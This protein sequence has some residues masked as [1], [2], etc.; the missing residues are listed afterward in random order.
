[1]QRRMA[2]LFIIVSLLGAS[3]AQAQI[4]SG[5]DPIGY[6]LNPF[7][8]MESTEAPWPGNF[9]GNKLRACSSGPDFMLL[10]AYQYDGVWAVGRSGFDKTPYQYP[11]LTMPELAQH[12]YFDE[13]DTIVGMASTPERDAVYLSFRP[14]YITASCSPIVKA[15]VDGTWEFAV[16]CEELSQV[17]EGKIRVQQLATDSA[18]LLYAVVRYGDEFDTRIL[19]IDTGQAE[20]D[21]ISVL[22]S[23]E[24]VFAQMDNLDPELVQIIKGPLAADD[25]GR[26][27]FLATV[28]ETTLSVFKEPADVLLRLDT[29]GTVTEMTLREKSTSYTGFHIE[30]YYPAR[31]CYVGIMYDPVDDMLVCAGNGTVFLFS[32]DLPLANRLVIDGSAIMNTIWTYGGQGVEHAPA[33]VVSPGACLGYVGWGENRAYAT[34]NYTFLLF[35]WDPM[36]LDLDGDFA[37]GFEEL[38][39]GTDPFVADT[40]GGGIKDG[41]EFIDFTD[42]LDSADD[43]LVPEFSKKWALPGL[44]FGSKAG[45]STDAKHAIGRWGVSM[46]DGSILVYSDGVNGGLHRFTDWD[47]PLEPVAQKGTIAGFMAADA[48]GAVYRRDGEAGVMH[49]APDGTE[50][51]VLSNGAAATLFGIEKV[52][53]TALETLPNKHVLVGYESGHLVDVDADGNA[54]VIYDAFADLGD[55]D[56]GNAEDCFGGCS[57]SLPVGP[58]TFEPDRGITYFW[59]TTHIHCYEG[60]G[61]MSYLVAMQPDGHFKTVADHWTFAE[62]ISTQGG[63]EPMDMVPDMK[64]GL[65]VLGWSLVGRGLL[66]LDADLAPFIVGG[67]EGPT[68]YGYGVTGSLWNAW[69]LMV[70]TEGRLFASA[71]YH[72]AM[73]PTTW[74][75][76][77]LVAVDDAIRPGDLLMVH[78]Y[79]NSLGKIPPTGGGILLHEG[80]PFKLP[81]AVAAADGRVAVVDTEVDQIFLA[82]VDD[83]GH[84]GAWSNL[85]PVSVPGGIDFDEDGNLLMTEK[86]AGQVLRIAPDGTSQIIAEK[87]ALDRP[88]DLVVM[89]NGDVAVTDD[90]L[91]RLLTISPDGSVHTVAE[92]ESPAALALVAGSHFVVSKNDNSSWPIT[93]DGS[94]LLG[95]TGHEAFGWTVGPNDVLGGMTAMPD[96]SV[97]W[98]IVTTK[99]WDQKVDMPMLRTLRLTPDGY[100]HPMMRGGSDPSEKPGDVCRY[101]GPGQPL[102]TAPGTKPLPIP[103][104]DPSESSAN[105]GGCGCTMDKQETSSASAVTVVLFLLAIF[106]LRRTR[107]TVVPAF[108]IAALS[109]GCGSG[110]NDGAAA[111]AIDVQIWEPETIAPECKGKDLCEPVS[112]PQCVDE[113]SARRC[114]PD[115]DGCW[116]WSDPATCPADAPCEGGICG[117]TWCQPQC[118]GLL[119]GDD[120]CG[121][122]CGECTGPDT[123]CGGVCSPCKQDCTGRECGWDGATGICGQCAEDLTCVDGTCLDQGEASCKGYFLDCLSQCQL[124]DQQCEKHCEAWLDSWA[125]QQVLDLEACQLLQ[126]ATCFE[127]AA[128]PDCQTQCVLS[129]CVDEY[130]ACY[131]DQGTVNC[132]DTYA[133]AEACGPDDFD[134]QNGC[135]DLATKEAFVALVQLVLCV[136]QFCPPDMPEPQQ[137][138]CEEEAMAETCAPEAQACLGPCEPLCPAWA[139][140]GPDSCTGLCGICPQGQTC[141]AGQ[142]LQP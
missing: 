11:I 69:D 36:L 114:M 108:L 63:I 78:P 53:L 21:R 132:A 118:A 104:E 33:T 123:C 26:V 59:L 97:V 126:C 3:R 92:I 112:P 34:Y 136:E 55:A 77:E 38:E 6:T 57:C 138:T 135:T 128:P 31:S 18:G 44:W 4:Y 66:H 43:R 129:T 87:P 52:T 117:G 80:E 22:A 103:D 79:A 137:T 23:S 102:P 81:T 91:G 105:D 74:G 42:P 133:C 111:D 2:V 116:T 12:Q 29:D 67:F 60:D 39:R 106:G 64:G 8:E 125:K 83:E 37:L 72:N 85:A 110:S 50:T 5:G 46:Q 115:Q 98:S 68:N 13:D 15:W 14:Y 130:S 100:V 32:P 88:V 19:K 30:Q 113:S 134:C 70:T 71:G 27:F 142:C 58:I 90:G 131:N 94:G 109:L 99:H 93:V 65:W 107:K 41:L 47:Q 124:W 86:L 139:N 96:G 61:F 122:S 141:P 48:T 62:L 40:D 45:L 127:E 54:T 7:V 84:L 24:E 73:S 28:S 119:C 17:A 35:S 101:R 9:Q 120:G 20:G 82:E 56:L 49:S 121:G 140:C 25:S 75:L 16:T 1:M 76:V 10:V 95:E 51:T 89:A